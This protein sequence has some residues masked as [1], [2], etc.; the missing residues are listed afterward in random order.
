MTTNY[1]LARGLREANAFANTLSE[2][3]EH[4][5]DPDTPLTQCGACNA[6]FTAL[7]DSMVT[8]LSIRGRRTRFTRWHGR[9]AARRPM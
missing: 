3:L 1:V 5:C 2:E 7:S 9:H 6:I 8:S 4:T